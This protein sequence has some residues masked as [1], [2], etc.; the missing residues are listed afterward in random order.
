MVTSELFR[1]C[2]ERVPAKD[3]AHRYGMEFD[4]RGWCRCPFHGDTHASMSFRQGRFRCWVCNASGDSIDFVSRLF[5]LEPLAALDRLN[6]DFS[7]NLPLHRAPKSEER[8]ALQR[9]QKLDQAHREFEAWRIRTIDQ[10]NAVYR[11]G[12]EA[13]KTVTDLDTLTEADTEAIRLMAWAEYLADILFFGTAAEQMQVFRGRREIQSRVQ[14][15]LMS[16]PP[17]KSQTA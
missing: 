14:V 7:L 8:Q 16:G 6:A 3:A 13:L 2:R 11:V 12:H 4:S 17:M 5:D 1:E 9:R 10:L 15:I